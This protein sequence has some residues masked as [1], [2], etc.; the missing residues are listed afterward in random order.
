MK[1]TEA[2]PAPYSLSASTPASIT[3]GLSAIPR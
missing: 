1:R 2:V 3:A